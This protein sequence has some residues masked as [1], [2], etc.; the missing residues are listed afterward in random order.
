MFSAI[1]RSLV[2]LIIHLADD[3]DAFICN[4]LI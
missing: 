3:A 4:Y 1:E 2:H